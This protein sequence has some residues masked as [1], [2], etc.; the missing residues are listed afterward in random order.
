ML[1]LLIQLLHELPVDG[2]ADILIVRQSIV[3]GKT[4][5]LASATCRSINAGSAAVMKK[6]SRIFYIISKKSIPFFRKLR[7]NVDIIFVRGEIWSMIGGL[8]LEEEEENAG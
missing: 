3:G 4:P 6:F 7:Y 2:L 1:N 8:F 5:V